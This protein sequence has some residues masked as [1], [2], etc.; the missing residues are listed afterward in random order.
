MDDDDFAQVRQQLRAAWRRSGKG[1]LPDTLTE[2]PPVFAIDRDG[3]LA[4]YLT[5]PAPWQFADAPEW[6]PFLPVPGLYGHPIYG[7]MDFYPERYD[8]IIGNF[9]SGVYQ[10]QLPVNAEHD[11]QASG[12][13]GWITDLRLN[14]DG[15]IDAQVEWND[16]GRQLIEGDRFRYVS[17]ELWSEWCDP[18]SPES[19]YRDVAVG[20]AVCTNPYFKESV[21]RPLMQSEAKVFT[22]TAGIRRKETNMAEGA[23]IEALEVIP[24][25]ITAVVELSDEQAREFSELKTLTARQATEITQLTERIAA[26][27]KATRI[28]AFTD[29][30]MGRSDASGQRWY[31]EVDK[32]VNH[33]VSLAEAFG[34]DSEQVAHYVAI[35]RAHAAQLAESN[36]FTEV[37]SGARPEGGNAWDKVEAAAVKLKEQQADLTMEQAR[38]AVMLSD[39]ALAAAVAAER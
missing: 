1:A 7:E 25:N 6:V 37:G 4:V 14:G 24:G 12:A 26:G 17:A 8:R 35:N 29:E 2:I 19:C 20:L 39:K 13:I 22:L 11:P 33:L 18:V 9:R 32:H 38:A 27:E 23:Q 30:V 3:R 5:E 10:A 28:R 16:R 15:S 34:E 21:L 31:G 36:L